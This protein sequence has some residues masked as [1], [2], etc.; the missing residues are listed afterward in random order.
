MPPKKTAAA[1]KAAAKDAPATVAKNKANTA[2]KVTKKPET[3]P[4]KTA[5]KAKAAETAKAPAKTRGRPKKQPEPEPVVESESESGAEA[6]SEEEQAEPETKTKATKT[7]A[8]G[9]HFPDICLDGLF[10]LEVRAAYLLRRW[11]T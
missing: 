7:K 2:A 11:P 5:A 1:S 4:K 8:K 9:E 6:D 10:A 3:A